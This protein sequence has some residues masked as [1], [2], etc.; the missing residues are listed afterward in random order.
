MSDSKY[1]WM[2][3]QSKLETIRIKFF[4]L[5]TK[6]IKFILSPVVWKPI[7]GTIVGAGLFWQIY[8][9]RPNLILEIE[10]FDKQP[11]YQKLILQN[12]GNR[13]AL[14][15]GI[16]IT[17]LK[18]KSKTS[19]WEW[20]NSTLGPLLDSVDFKLNENQKFKFSLDQFRDL[21]SGISQ[22]EWASGSFELEVIYDDFIIKQKA[23]YFYHLIEGQWQQMG[24][25]LNK[26]LSI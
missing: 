8:N 1:F 20:K 13:P 2:T 16:Y 15:K 9:N 12:S 4:K 25:F 22:S 10:N 5:L 24:P 7:V 23:I 17:G 11:F 18:L 14:I 19:H 3:L 6:I 21:P 26:N